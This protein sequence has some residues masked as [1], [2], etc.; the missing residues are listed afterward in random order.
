MLLESYHYFL[1]QCKNVYVTKKMYPSSSNC[2][3]WNGE[4][5][6]GGH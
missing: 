6:N 5:R 1:S 3:E 4:V 2:Q